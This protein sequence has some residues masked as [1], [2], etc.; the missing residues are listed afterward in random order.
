L[1][2][3]Q[4]NRR[5]PIRSA[6]ALACIISAS[7]PA[8]A[9]D[10]AKPAEKW[11]PRDGLYVVAGTG[12]HDRCMDDTQLDI[13]LREKS[14]SGHEWSCEVTRLTDTAPGIIRL[15]MTCNDYN[16][17]EF[18]NDNDPNPYDRQFKEVMLLRKMDEKSISVRKT[19]NGKFKDP[20]WRAAYCPKDAQRSHTEAT[21]RNRA[22]A[23]QKAAAQRKWRP[24]DGAYAS[25]GADFGDRCLRSRDVIIGL[26]GNSVSSGV[27]NCSISNIT[28]SPPDGINL[29]LICDQK[30]GTPG[31][32]SGGQTIAEGPTAEAMILRKVDD[33]TISLRK[34]QNGEFKE[35][36]RQLSYCGEQAQRAQAQP[37]KKD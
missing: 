2:C 33:K 14:I 7:T 36:D 18:I 24:R 34:T 25:R 31:R 32:V 21:A 35:P 8:L 26:A 12:L 1:S 13:D 4:R 6:I 3:K 30:L 9:Q 27:A 19:V 22:E 29:G 17:A 20:E 28:E 37:K 23:A 16:L 15:D 10:S 11:R 5:I